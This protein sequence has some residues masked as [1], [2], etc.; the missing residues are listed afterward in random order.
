MYEKKRTLYYILEN[1]LCFFWQNYYLC[2][3]FFTYGHYNHS[4]RVSWNTFWG[5]CQYAYTAFS[6]Q[7][8]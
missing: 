3:L 5:S 6:N 1:S 4:Y 2:T 7:T 8:I